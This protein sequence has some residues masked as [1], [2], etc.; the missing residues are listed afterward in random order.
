MFCELQ[1]PGINLATETLGLKFTCGPNLVQSLMQAR[2]C[3]GAK[4]QT[5]TQLY[6]RDQAI[7]RLVIRGD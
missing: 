1:G 2:E 7:T 6:V 4:S 5:L 3:K